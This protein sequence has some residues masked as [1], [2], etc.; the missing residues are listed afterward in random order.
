VKTK[1]EA[2]IDWW[3]LCYWQIFAIYENEACLIPLVLKGL[4]RQER[5]ICYTQLSLRKFAA[6]RDI[7]NRAYNF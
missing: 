1:A 6:L 5:P 3:W 4:G 7:E 2:V